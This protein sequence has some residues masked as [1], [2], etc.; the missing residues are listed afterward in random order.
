MIE[1]INTIPHMEE[2]AGAP[3][4]DGFYIGPSDLAVSMGLGPPDYRGNAKHAE[5][6]QKVLIAAKKPWTGSRYPLRI[7]KRSSATDR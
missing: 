6:C 2:L 3:G 5:A 4:I 1:D 7:A